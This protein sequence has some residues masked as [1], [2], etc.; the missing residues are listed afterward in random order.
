MKKLILLFCCVAISY[1]A[2]AQE[3]VQTKEMGVRF[4]FIPNN[5][6]F[7]LI[8]DNPQ[9]MSKL[10]DFID[11]NFEAIESGKLVVYV[12]GYSSYFETD[13]ENLMSAKIRS[14][15]VKSE[16]I[17]KNGL[18]EGNFRTKNHATA[19]GEYESVVVVEIAAPGAQT[20]LS[21][22]TAVAPV[23][24]STADAEA[25]KQEVE[26]AK[27][28]AEEILKAAEAEAAKKIAEAEAIKN[29]A[30]IEAAKVAEQAAAEARQR[31]AEAEEARKL[32]EEV[33]SN[34][35]NKDKYC[36]AVRGNLLYWAGLLPTLG[37]EWRANELIGVKVDGS[38][39]SWTLGKEDRKH[40]IM[41]VSPELRFYLLK[42]RRFYLGLGGNFGSADMSWKPFSALFTAT[43]GYKGSL[44]GGGL[45]VGY[46]VRLA[47]RFSLDLNIGLGGTYYDYEIYN[48]AS[49][50]TLKSDASRMFWGPTQAGISLVWRIGGK[51]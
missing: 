21:D 8:N 10:S 30:E 9:E 45:V 38:F 33:E 48:V 2:A 36:F 24:Q 23:G 49:G 47:E 4:R 39:S 28:E 12:N 3:N 42:D 26:A 5:D 17:L 16:L 50:T 35:W 40:N 18:V 37:I 32:A 6:I 34:G 22:Q 19:L 51:K 44:Y 46:Q 27:K 41:M 29:T 25:S 31:V 14:N 20:Q 11:T 15:R 13:E 7:F 43:N 1:I